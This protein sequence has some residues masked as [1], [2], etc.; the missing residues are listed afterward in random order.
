MTGAFDV[1]M[2]PTHGLMAWALALALA[3]S[4]H[5]AK[6]APGNAMWVLTGVSSPS[7]LA[8]QMGAQWAWIKAST[9]SDCSY[10]VTGSQVDNGNQQVGRTAKLV[11]RRG[12]MALGFWV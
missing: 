2:R 5:G 9:K 10:T 1:I 12:C 3:T 11:Q 8:T 4:A 7:C 6:C